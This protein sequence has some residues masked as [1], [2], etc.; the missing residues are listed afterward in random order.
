MSSLLSWLWA[1]DANFPNLVLL[2]YVSASTFIVLCD[3][4]IVGSVALNGVLLF[5][6]YWKWQFNVHTSS[7]ST[8][9]FNGELQTDCKNNI[10]SLIIQ[11]NMTKLMLDVLQYP[12]AY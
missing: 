5:C 12:G 2:L 3:S 1:G 9:L 6:T 4:F 10:L 11:M 7:S 8:D